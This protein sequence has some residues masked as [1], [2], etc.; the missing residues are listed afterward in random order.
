MSAEGE[1][2][3]C[4]WILDLTVVVCVVVMVVTRVLCVEEGEW[5][6]GAECGH[7][8]RTHAWLSLPGAEERT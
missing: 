4:G 3:Y 2:Q 6:G 7:A 5:G 8:R 1:E